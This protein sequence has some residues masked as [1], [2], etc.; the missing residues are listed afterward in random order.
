MVSFQ[1]PFHGKNITGS[2][3]GIISRPQ[4]NAPS[5]SVTS[6]LRL[7]DRRITDPAGAIMGSL[8]S[9]DYRIRTAVCQARLLGPLYP[10]RTLSR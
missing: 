9:T 1:L 6:V 10:V 4:S 7:Q 5:S 8:R 3:A 2:R